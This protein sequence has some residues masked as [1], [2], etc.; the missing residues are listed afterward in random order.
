M[1]YMIEHHQTTCD[2]FFNSNK[3]SF[4]CFSSNMSA[5]KLNL[6]IDSAMNIIGSS[7]HVLDLGVSISSNCT[8]TFTFLICIN[9][10]QTLLAGFSERL[11]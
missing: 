11:L 5:Y 7:T 4:V 3:F 6:Y 1:L 2:M 8:L 10:A 9:D